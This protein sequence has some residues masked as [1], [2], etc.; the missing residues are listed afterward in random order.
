L[1]IGTSPTFGPGERKLEVY[2]LDE[3]VDLYGEFLSVQFV[4]RLRDDRTFAAEA[5]LAACI[6]GDVARARELLQDAALSGVEA[7][8]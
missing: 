5:D 4:E 8:R 7:Y 3:V 6:E 1:Y 2:L